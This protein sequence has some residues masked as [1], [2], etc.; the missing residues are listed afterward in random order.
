MLS[1]GEIRLIKK[2]KKEGLSIS[3]IAKRLGSCRNTVKRYL[4]MQDGVIVKTKEHHHGSQSALFLDKIKEIIEAGKKHSIIVPATAI[5][6]EI[7]PLGYTGQIRML[8]R[9]IKKYKLRETP[10]S[11]PDPVIRFE[12]EPGI[13]LQVDWIE[14]KKEKLSAFVA[15]LGFSRYAYVEYV[16]NESFE[17]IRECHI[18]AFAY[19]G[20]VPREILYDNMKTVVDKRNLYGKDNHR[21][22][23][24]FMELSGYYGFKIRLCRPYRAKTKGKVERFNSYLR[25]SFHNPLKAKLASLGYS[26]DKTTANAEVLKWLEFHANE[27]IHQTTMQIPS[28]LL[29][30]E[31]ECLYPLPNT[32]YNA[33]SVRECANGIVQITTDIYEVKRKIK[34]VASLRAYDAFIPNTDARI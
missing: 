1:I 23:P 2:L 18:N 20:G 15:V 31:K 29:E 32:P 30:Q 7:R 25:H 21:F 26:I 12:T 16:T 33:K 11:R 3:E 17:T 4:K 24:S 5:L 34:S 8:Q 19:F 13:Q 6:R 27:R 10:V 9:T 22:N 14:F 28:R